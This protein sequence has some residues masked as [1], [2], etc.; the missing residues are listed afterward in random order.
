M[1]APRRAS[2]GRTKLGP[3]PADLSRISVTAKVAAY[4]RQFSDIP[5]AKEVAARIHADDAF[6]QIVRDHALD[7]DQLTFYAPMFEARYKSITQ[8][9][10]KAGVSQ[11]LELAC[12]YSLR[13]LDLTRES[14]I[15]YVE[16]DLPDV[17]AT[18]LA[19][20]DDVRRHHDIAPSPLHVV[21]VA[22]ALDVEQLRTAAAPFDAGKPLMILSEG[23]IGYLTRQEIERLAANVHDVLG[24]FA[25]S[26]WIC[27]DFSFKV[28]LQ[29]LPPERVRLREAITGITERQLDA[30]AFEDQSDLATFLDRHG[31]SVHVRSQVDETPAFSSIP[32]LG[33]SPALIERMRP[34]LRAWVMTPKPKSL[35]A[36]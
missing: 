10:Q 24:A 23:L 11:V 32:A 7:R 27:P 4:Y 16:T 31:F 19:L 33:L 2:D 20:L 5:F 36:S 12:G 13:G 6:A 28:D 26:S 3:V 30:S 1:I 8:L 34:A 29:N 17:V 25:G 22:D 9:I 15:R 35:I 14:T 18:K 21:T